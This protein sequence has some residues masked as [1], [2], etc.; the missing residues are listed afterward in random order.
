MYLLVMRPDTLSQGIGD[1]G[2]LHSLRDLDRIIS[3]EEAPTKSPATSREEVV[4]AILFY[5]ESYVI[6]DIRFQFRWKETKSAV[7]GGDRL[8][9]QLR[10]LGFKKWWEI[11]KEV[12]MEMLAYAAAHCPWKEH[13]QQLRRG[14]ELVTHV[15]FLML[16]LGLSEQYEYNSLNDYIRG[17]DLVLPWVSSIDYHLL[18]FVS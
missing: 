13:A 9:K 11:I 5:Y 8:A 17:H 6:D 18:I 12:W 2:Y 10:L 15:Y 14:G 3:K 4:D 1:E 16:H 7:A